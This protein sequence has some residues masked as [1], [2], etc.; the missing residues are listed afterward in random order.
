MIAV[1]EL[2]ECVW[3]TIAL[4]LAPEAQGRIRST[5]KALRRA[6][7]I[8]V[9]SLHVP[10]DPHLTG[11]QSNL[12]KRCPNLTSLC[13]QLSPT[14]GIA[15]QQAALQQLL[16]S[17]APSSRGQGLK[18]LRL[19]P[20][21]LPTPW[22]PDSLHR[23]AC[24]LGPHLSALHLYLDQPL[25]AS[26]LLHCL[27]ASLTTLTVTLTPRCFASAYSPPHLPQ[28]LELKLV[29]RESPTPLNP[30][31][32]Q[33]SAVPSSTQDTVAVSSGSRQPDPTC[34]D[35]RLPP[36]STLLPAL[37][38]VDQ[39]LSW[40]TV[41][42]SEGVVDPGTL[43]PLLPVTLRCLSVQLAASPAPLSLP[44]LQP[45]TR[46]TSLVTLAVFD[47]DLPWLLLAASCPA[48]RSLR[49]WGQLQVL[50]VDAQ[51]WITRWQQ[52][53]QTSPSLADRPPFPVLW[54]LYL[55]NASSP[56]CDGAARAILG[57][58]RDLNVNG[59]A[60]HSGL[61][62]VSGLEAIAVCAPLLQYLHVTVSTHWPSSDLARLSSV[63]CQRLPHLDRLCIHCIAQD[64]HLGHSSRA[65]GLGCSTP[66]DDGPGQGTGVGSDGAGAGVRAAGL[67]DQEQ[68]L[69]VSHLEALM[70]GLPR[71]RWLRVQGWQLDA[72]VVCRLQRDAPRQVQLVI[73]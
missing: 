33:Q 11:Q 30:V 4:A 71:L 68:G 48:L 73:S 25:A 34:S 35:R 10:L 39:R 29:C 14:I 24:V 27:P 7:D 1:P 52:L 60:P 17:V 15:A 38:R 57:Q 26:V 54:E 19:H 45:L 28:L 22:T 61:V 62:T 50:S 65:A 66:S 21:H 2:P 16:T 58:V 59:Q 5:C 20:E 6:A 63:W 46:L 67:E 3:E 31:V 37:L 51:T 42:D 13:V 40:L 49:V 12:I 72:E 44:A 56:L 53:Q 32:G 55:R 47:L 43:L 41:I 36:C 69:Q 9:C 70:Q 23:A 64:L 18:S 8:A